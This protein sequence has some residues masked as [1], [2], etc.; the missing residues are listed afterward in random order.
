LL[1][2]LLIAVWLELKNPG[3]RYECSGGVPDTL[4]DWEE[5]TVVR[6]WPD[7]PVIYEGTV[8]NDTINWSQTSY[9]YYEPWKK[10]AKYNIH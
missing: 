9:E 4:V 8:V 3:D 1:P 10:R 2:F 6:Y 5:K 7:G